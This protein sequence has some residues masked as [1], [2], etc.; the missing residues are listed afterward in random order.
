MLSGVHDKTDLVVGRG[1]HIFFFRIIIDYWAIF[2]KVFNRLGK[3]LT[4]MNPLL[5]MDVKCIKIFPN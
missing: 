4:K 3:R 5:A 1:A 2:A